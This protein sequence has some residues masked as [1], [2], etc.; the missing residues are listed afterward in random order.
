MA[1]L[2]AVILSPVEMLGLNL[3]RVTCMHPPWKDEQG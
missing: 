3:V 2:Y 1:G